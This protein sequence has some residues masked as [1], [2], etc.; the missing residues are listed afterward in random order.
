MKA[1]LR[2]WLRSRLP[3]IGLFL[4]CCAVFAVVFRLYVL[5]LGAVGYPALLCGVLWLFYALLRLRRGL[6]KHRILSALTAD[7][8]E[9]MLPAAD[10]VED[11]DYR[12]IIA[13]LR[14]MTAELLHTFEKEF[15]TAVQKGC[16][17]AVLQND[18]FLDS[19]IASVFVD[20]AGFAGAECLRRTIGIAK[21]PEFDLL[22]KAQRVQFERKIMNA[23]V[24][25]MEHMHSLNSADALLT[26]IEKNS[27]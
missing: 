14:E 27:N 20:T 8:T 24:L 6:Q 7:L 9:D 19:F 3:A 12:R 1:F 25:L 17:D 23:G 26:M 5:P 15:R 18:R 11:E 4:L 10:T 16:T 22:E 2:P 21:I 13:L